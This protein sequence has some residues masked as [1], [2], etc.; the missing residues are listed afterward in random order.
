SRREPR[1]RTLTLGAALLVSTAAV[2]AGP[3]IMPLREPTLGNAIANVI[4]T[5]T[6]NPHLNYY[7]GRILDQVKVYNV[8]WGTSVNSTVQSRIGDFYSAVVV[9]PM[10]DWLTEYNTNITAQGGGAGTNQIL[11]HGSYAGSI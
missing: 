4:N 5:A 1:M 2:A 8:N 7:G 3:H 9:S 6:A 10:F 11:K